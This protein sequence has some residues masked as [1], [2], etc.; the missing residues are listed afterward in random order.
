MMSRL[1]KIVFLC[2]CFAAVA[3]PASALTIIPTFG[4]GMSGNAAAMAVVNNAISFYQT[5][6]SDPIIVSIAFNDM[7]SLTELGTSEFLPLR[8]SYA[9]FSTALA[10][11]ATSAD[12]ATAG[13]SA[14]TNNPVNG[15]TQLLVKSANLRAIGIAQVART[16]TA[17]DDC[18]GGMI[19]VFDG[20]IGLN[21]ADTDIS[22]GPFS[23]LAVTEHEID[24]ILGLGSTLGTSTT[25]P[26]PSP[27]DL[28]RY[29]SG[30]VRSYAANLGACAASPLGDGPLAY[31]S[32]DG[33]ATNLDPFDNCN[34]GGDY[35]DWAHGTPAQVQDAFGTSGA[36]PSLS[37]ISVEV[38]ALDVIGYTLKTDAVP[39]PE[40]ATFA[41]LATGLAGLAAFA[42]RRAAGVEVREL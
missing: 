39:T 6:F 31:F 3:R 16:W 42:R 22:G 32:I 7:S 37:S 25:A 5:T 4:A 28:F 23:L 14:A 17:G 12:D 24:E 11:D 9:D 20:C 18:D 41:L 38:R 1:S 13:I 8:T 34:N 27:E 15:A 26:R 2:G 10:G 29:S 33:G 21:L 35:G 36:T 19:G 40:P 30:G